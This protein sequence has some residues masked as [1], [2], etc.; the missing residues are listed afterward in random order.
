[1]RSHGILPRA[2]GPRYVGWIMRG[3]QAPAVLRELEINPLMSYL[4]S[5]PQGIEELTETRVVVTMLAIR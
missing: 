5:H 2:D 1:M 3:M 4:E